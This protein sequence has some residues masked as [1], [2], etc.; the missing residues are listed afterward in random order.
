MCRSVVIGVEQSGRGPAGRLRGQLPAQVER[1]LQ[2]EVESLAAHRHLPVGGVSRQEDPVLAVPGRLTAG[3]SEGVHPDRR[4][5]ADVL[6]GDPSPYLGDVRELG[7]RRCAVRLGAELVDHDAGDAVAASGGDGEAGREPLK[8]AVGY[9]NAGHIGAE[10][11]ASRA[12]VPGKSK[13]ASRRSVLSSPSQPDE[14]AADAH[15]APGRRGQRPR[16]SPVRPW[17][18]GRIPRDSRRMS[19]TQDRRPIRPAVPQH[20]SAELST[21][22]DSGWAAR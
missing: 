12:S 11:F 8:A 14:V 1:V 18:S 3:I 20:V 13:F 4:S 17:W 9:L 2:A 16:R 15:A 22:P 19:D 10:Q 6:A 7:A 21:G 5:S